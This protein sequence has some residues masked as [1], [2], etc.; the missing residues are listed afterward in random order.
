MSQIELDYLSSFII[1]GELEL[2]NVSI[3]RLAEN[4]PDLFL[5]IHNSI[6]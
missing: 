1:P 2:Y 4:K 3:S 5:D 6:I